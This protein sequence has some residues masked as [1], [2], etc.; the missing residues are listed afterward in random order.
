MENTLLSGQ[1]VP[2]QI[3]ADPLTST[4]IQ[5]LLPQLDANWQV[6]DGKKLVRDFQCQN[7]TQAVALVTAIAQAAEEQGHH[8]DL[9]LHDF[10][11]LQVSW[12]THKIG[13][14]HQ[15]DFIM[16]A[17]TDEIFTKGFA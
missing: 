16:A 17:R 14:L 5:E 4:Q 11:F 13:G 9:L 2:C 8:P 15:N 7:F 12:W 6:A 10:K 1:C 3:G